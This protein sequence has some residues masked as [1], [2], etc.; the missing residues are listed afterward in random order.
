[1]NSAEFFVQYRVKFPASWLVKAAGSSGEGKKVSIISSSFHSNT[2]FEHVIQDLSCR[3]IVQAYRQTDSIADAYN[4]NNYQYEPFS[5]GYGA[6]DFK[7][8]PSVGASTGRYCLYS[9]GGSGYPNCYRFTPDVWMCIYQ[10]IRVATYGGTSG[11][12]YDLFAWKPGEPGYTQLVGHRNYAIGGRGQ[13][14]NGFN[15]LWLLPYTS[16]RTSSTVDSYVL[17][18]QVVVSSKPIPC[19]AV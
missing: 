18:D 6:Y 13:Y 19:P 16:G 4:S 3:N 7:L 14:A 1:M 5:E 12:E 11:N 17:Y 9:T 10:R 2:S 15:G 8:Q